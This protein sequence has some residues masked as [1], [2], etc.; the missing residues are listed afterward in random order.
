MVNEEREYE[1]QAHSNRDN[2][3]IFMAVRLPAMK[4]RPPMGL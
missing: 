3:L 2:L 4:L 1:C